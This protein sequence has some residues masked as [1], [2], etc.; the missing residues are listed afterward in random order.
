MKISITKKISVLLLMPIIGALLTLVVFYQYNHEIETDNAYINVAG[1]QRMLSKQL[2]IYADMVR[3]GQEE[4]RPLLKETIT[5]FDHALEALEKG[6]EVMGF[7][8]S[9]PPMVVVKAVFENRKIW[10]SYKKATLLIA[11]QPV[12]DSEALQAYEYI[13]NNTRALTESSSSIVTTMQEFG[14]ARHRKMVFVMI[15]IAA[16]DFLLFFVCLKMIREYATNNKQH[17]ESLQNIV[18]HNQQQM[19]ALSEA[20]VRMALI[21]GASEALQNADKVLQSDGE[22][23]EFYEK[24]I[25]ELGVN[26]G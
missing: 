22:L 18:D 13:V 4:D 21:A 6:G 5:T 15:V 20:N 19:I 26:D 24:V 1:H 9:P 3:I 11:D 12:D 7:H 25:D 17:E 14:D 8:L 16:I 23:N 10:A 2:Y